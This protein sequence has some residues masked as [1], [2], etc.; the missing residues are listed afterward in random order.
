MKLNTKNPAVMRK[1]KYGAVSIILTAVVVAAVIIFNAI[2]SSLVYKYNWYVDMTK[3]G[4]YGLSDAGRAMLDNI[5]APIN[6]IFCQPYD[7]LE[8]STAT[9]M[10]F[11][12]VKEMAAS[13]DN[14]TYEYIDIISNPTAITKYKTTTAT[15]ISTTDVIVESGTEFRVFKWNALFV[16]NESNVIWAFNGELKLI[17][18][19]IQ[20]TQAET[21]IAYYTYTHGESAS[22]EMLGLLELLANAGYS[23]QPID[24]SKEDPSEDA[25]LIVIYNP[26]YD[27]EGISEDTA[28]RK[29]EIEKIDDFLDGWGNLMVFIDPDTGE[30]P[31]LDE[32]LYEWGIEFDNSVLKDPSSSLD[33]EHYSLVGE[34]SVEE[35]LGASLVS[36][37]TSLGTPPKTVVRY[38]RPINLLWDGSNGRTTSTVLY[39]SKNAEKYVDG[40]KVDEGQYPLIALSREMRY[41][42]NTPHY[43][44][45]FVCGSQ[46]LTSTDYLGRKAYG[47]SDIVYAMMRQMGKTQVPVDLDF[48]VFDDESLD[49]TTQE[50]TNWTIF[51]TAV[52]PALFLIAGVVVWIRR[53][54]A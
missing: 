2:F 9:K 45:V 21:P 51:L 18:A 32:F 13:Y 23:V 37:M 6:I 19:M 44:Y 34:Y 1:F 49:I 52:I 25:R 7:Q 47:N 41:I 26:R 48:K 16:Q 35:S 36:S 29:S 5:D 20:I 11:S 33:V 8:S 38:A 54:H 31:E 53:K 24:L 15:S 4:V 39:T 14:I 43:S 10:I 46:Y 17:S 3:E 27:F 42:D 22:M 30:L 12:L 28:G 50:A 40:N